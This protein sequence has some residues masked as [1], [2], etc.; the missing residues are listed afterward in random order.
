MYTILISLE[1]G[2]YKNVEV[3]PDRKNAQPRVE[4]E[5]LKQLTLLCAR[6][7]PDSLECSSPGNKY[8]QYSDLC[9]LFWF[10]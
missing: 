2:Q 4:E 8:I 6:G 10:C 3:G 9:N 1:E 5:P 7:F